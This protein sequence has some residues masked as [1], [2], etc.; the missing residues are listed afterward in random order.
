MMNGN[1]GSYMS[2]HTISHNDRRCHILKIN[3]SGIV[4]SDDRGIFMYSESGG[5]I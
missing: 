2:G 3:T 4:G 5:P 1:N